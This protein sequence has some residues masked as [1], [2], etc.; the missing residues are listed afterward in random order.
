MK[1]LWLSM[2]GIFITAFLP[3]R[4]QDIITEPFEN[5]L[6][7][8]VSDNSATVLSYD[9][10][11]AFG[12]GIAG[13]PYIAGVRFDAAT[14]SQYTGYFMNSVDVNI[15]IVPSG[16]LKVNIYRGGTTANPGPVV[17]SKS[18][19]QDQLLAYSWNTITIDS[20]LTVNNANQDLW[21]G[22]QLGAQNGN[23]VCLTV[24]SGPA[25]PDGNRYFVNNTWTTLNS[26][27][28]NKNWNIRL[29]ISQ[30]ILQQTAKV[31]IVHNS[32]DPLVKKVDVY[33][34]NVKTL[35]NF[36]YK[37]ALPFINFN[38]N[39][40]YY[41]T[42]TLPGQ[43]VSNPLVVFTTSFIANKNYIAAV[44]GDVQSGFRLT[45]RPDALVF[46]DP[47]VSKIQVFHGSPDA[48]PVDIRERTAGLLFSNVAFGEY[49]E[50]KSLFPNSY[51]IDL[52]LPGS[53]VPV[54][55]FNVD[56]RYGAGV[57][58]SVFATGY[59]NPPAQNY[60][61][62]RLFGVL[63][64]G[65][66][67]DFPRI[68]T[69]LAPAKVQIVH[70]SPDPLVKK[71][72]VYVNGQKSLSNFSYKNALPFLDLRPYENYDFALTLPGQPLSS[73]LVTFSTSFLPGT[74]Y[75]A[76]IQGD[77]QS[78]FFLLK[79]EN[80]ETSGNS[81]TARIQ[82]LHGSPDAPPVDIRE[83]NAGLLFSSL[84]YGSFT[85]YISLSPNSYIIDVAL[86]GTTTPVASFNVDLR[87]GA[88]LVAS[89]F[90][91][92]YLNPQAQ[93]YPPFRLFG[94][95][96]TGNVIE[97][98]RI[99]TVPPAGNARIQIIHNSP[100]PAAANVDVY[101][102]GSLTLPGF[103]YKQATPF[104]DFVP[105]R[106]YNIT[107]VPAGQPFSQGIVTFT[108]N[109]QANK[110]YIAAVQ[111]DLDSGVV[112]TIKPD[113]LLSGDPLLTTIQVFHGSV[114][115]PAVD[116]RERSAGVLFG[117]L[118]FR[119]YTDY[120]AIP[121]SPYV[122]DI[123]LPGS[124]VPVAS[125]AV[126]LTNA[127]GAV[128]TVLA[129][130]YLSPATPAFP[131]FKLIGVL[132]DGSV[133]EFPKIDSVIVPPPSG[134]FT[135]SIMDSVFYFN[136]G[137]I[138]FYIP[139]K[140]KN[141]PAQGYISY[142][143][144]VLYD[145]SYFRALGISQN[146]TLT[147]TNGWTALANVLTPGVI[148]I[149]AFGASN[150]AADGDL[151]HLRFLL[152]GREGSSQLR[153]RNFV[154]N[155]GNPSVQT[156]NGNITLIARVC[157][158]ANVDG[159]VFAE[160][161]SLTLQHSIGTITLTPQGIVNADVDETG[162][163]TSFDAA[164]I[165]RNVLGLPQPVN[166]CFGSALAKSPVTAAIIEASSFRMS[167]NN[168][169]ISLS[170]VAGS[171]KVYA[172]EFDI[173]AEAGRISAADLRYSGQSVMGYTNKISDNTVRVAIIAAEGF[174]TGDFTLEVLNP[175]GNSTV[176]VSNL[177]VNGNSSAGFKMNSSSVAGPA[178]YNLAGAYP[179][180]FNPSTNIQFSV[181]VSGM[182]TLEVY[183]ILGSKVRTLISDVL[184]AGTRTV[185]FDARDDF[186][187]G[188]AS[189]NYIVLM[190]A[191]SFTKSIKI[192][193]LK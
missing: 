104:L 2:L 132:T 142:Q 116:I 47:Q 139:V 94:V 105:N 49:T 125:F 19:P 7:D 9:G 67:I 77:T 144:D 163:I 152:T 126:D 5:S 26:M 50:Y 119:S 78:G 110:K 53:T 136:P 42:L 180:P 90:A 122:I 185:T 182:V 51:V 87:Y 29:N 118:S 44:Q 171:E 70:N 88:G 147:G 46:G 35:S 75:I 100:E 121:P 95:L 168:G 176:T 101:I 11:P 59:L 8:P 170:N 68:D 80:A 21:V 156:I 169:L 58:A 52:T 83:R 111:G 55:S 187:K 158:D 61:P 177:K 96:A 74:N 34:N 36:E 151:I 89:V 166:T 133:I 129:T 71:V 76:A 79:R 25:A 16:G 155:S 165:L 190:R 37:K 13:K 173:T 109:P 1:K 31:Q 99:D 57:V 131:P 159:A 92:G 107:L 18:V 174:N 15:R 12:V 98:P 86:P 10:A 140:M 193:L 162:S 138:D 143:F 181:P 27:G 22:V 60:P 23:V 149:G 184:E 160:D 64:N 73:A 150:I 39:Q 28:V 6:P 192:N 102:N 153:L 113:V 186:G 115:A 130:G 81:Q 135:A 106:N 32:P 134:N 17:Y 161:A 114:D 24:D 117:N 91:T 40:L 103:R 20:N 123:T 145:T 183:D 124:P 167:N 66:V 4:A 69:V 14:L 30:Q 38:S 127:A 146:G 148:R 84:E 188:L 172:M 137:N 141:T 65:N 93:N 154:V 175:S 120:I 3:L 62:L 85:D 43:P 108:V 63:T 97:F 128:A 54:A 189:G 179:N 164:L 45:L 112:L 157:G 48:P 33:I 191:G 82:V 178:D 56:L 41:I 72:D